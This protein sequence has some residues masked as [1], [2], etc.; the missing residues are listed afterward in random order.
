VGLTEKLDLHA[1]AAAPD[2]HILFRGKRA[3]VREGRSPYKD[4]SL[5]GNLIL[6]NEEI[7]LQLKVST[8][9]VE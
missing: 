2:F 5:P 4:P 8:G 6:Q 3:G 7:S 9:P 1:L